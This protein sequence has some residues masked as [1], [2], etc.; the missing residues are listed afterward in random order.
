MLWRWLVTEVW[1][2][3]GFL[4]GLLPV[5]KVNGFSEVF[6]SR[7]AQPNALIELGLRGY[8]R[9]GLSFDNASA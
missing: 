4:A 5:G 9:I 7:S 3:E 8:N 1:Q 2:P 6:P